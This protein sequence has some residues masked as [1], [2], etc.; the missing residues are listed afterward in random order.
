M[1]RNLAVRQN[2]LM[3]V[4]EVVS[5]PS[6]LWQNPYAER[7]IGSLRRECLDHVIMLNQTH[8]RRLLAR[9]GP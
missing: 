2:A 6:G 1:N 7:M 9:Y 8:L 4:A 3:A 5:A